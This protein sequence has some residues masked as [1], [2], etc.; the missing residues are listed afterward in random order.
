MDILVSN[1]AVNPSVG[2]VLDTPEEVWDKIFD[3]NVKCTYLLMKESLPLLK[4][5]KSPSIIIIGSIAGYNHFSV[6]YFER[7]VF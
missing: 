4:Q 2:S 1:A 5:S 6:S 3:V 7:F